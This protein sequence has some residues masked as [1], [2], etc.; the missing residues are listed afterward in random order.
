MV[1]EICGE[2]F[3]LAVQVPLRARL[4][5]LDAEQHVLVVVIHHIATDGWSAG[6]LARDLSVAY[7]ARRQG[8]VPGWAPLPV[9]YADYA[10]WQRDLLGDP[11]DPDSVLAGQV[12]WWR[13][14]LAGMPEELAL[15]ADRPRPPVPSHRGITAAL[16]VPAPV[17]AG[18][19][20][21][22]RRQGVTMF[23]VIQAALAVLL[24]R[25]GAR[26]RYPGRLAGRR[27]YR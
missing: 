13:Q 5:R 21:L 22:A 2:P 26:H 25:L 11:D 18:L 10:I 4:L 1:A 8:Q 12:G 24:A 3:D 6:P 27:A 15:P 20:G 17:H 14:A 16:E 23:M 9:Q 19:A 7:A